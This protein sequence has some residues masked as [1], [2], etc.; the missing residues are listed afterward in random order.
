MIG[1]LAD[2]ERLEHVLLF[3]NKIRQTWS[4]INSWKKI[5][6]VQT[7]SGNIGQ[8]IFHVL[9]ALS[10]EEKCVFA[11]TIWSWWRCRNY[12]IQENKNKR[13]KEIIY[14]GNYLLNEWRA[15]CQ[16]AVQAA[17]TAPYPWQSTVASSSS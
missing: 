9:G 11:I 13:S 6:Q 7:Q 4:N 8:K 1:V 15:A 14:R 17:S 12:T 10:T 3:C 16:G 2:L 5:T